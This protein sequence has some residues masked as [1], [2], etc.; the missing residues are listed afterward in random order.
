MPSPIQA[1]AGISIQNHQN[2]PEGTKSEMTI[3]ITRKATP[4][5][6]FSKAFS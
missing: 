2:L 6:R 3:E 4:T 5:P 1:K